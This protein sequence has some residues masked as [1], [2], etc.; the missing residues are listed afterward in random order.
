MHRW[1]LLI[2]YIVIQILN[3]QDKN[4]GS[5]TKAAI[6][7][8]IER[9]SPIAFYTQTQIEIKKDLIKTIMVNSNSEFA[10]L[11]DEFWYF[12]A[13]KIVENFLS[14]MAQTKVPE[15]FISLLDGDKKKK[16]QISLLKGQTL[17]PSQLFALLVNAETKGCTFSEYHYQA[18]PPN[19]DTEKLPKMIEIKEDGNVRS[20][21]NKGLS[22]G[23]MKAAVEQTK[24]IVAKVLDKGDE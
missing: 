15:N 18:T 11:P 17:T 23:Q 19:I 9:V 21:G 7:E 24:K 8:D 13:A 20:I 22:D 3:F 2:K 4:D 10:T 12:K 14:D 1:V 6:L 5:V 16:E